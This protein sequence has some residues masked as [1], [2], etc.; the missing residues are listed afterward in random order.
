[1]IDP[2]EVLDPVKPW[3]KGKKGEGGGERAPKKAKSDMPRRLQQLLLSDDEKPSFE[4]LDE[5]RG[6]EQHQAI[7][8]LTRVHGIGPV[9]GGNGGGVKAGRG[10]RAP[11]LP[12]SFPP[13]QTVIEE[14]TKVTTPLPT[15]SQ[16]VSYS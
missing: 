16:R 9:T 3:H 11:L 1:M 5:L 13:C 8:A 15:A 7:L 12:P 14:A 4:L 2:T 6:S 10:G